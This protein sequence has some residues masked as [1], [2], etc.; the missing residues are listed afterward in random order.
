MQKQSNLIFKKQLLNSIYEHL[1]SSAGDFPALWARRFGLNFVQRK[2]LSCSCDA[3][4][5]SPSLGVSSL[6][7]GRRMA[8]LFLPAT[9]AA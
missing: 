7:L 9:P 1:K 3:L 2:L 5:R 4:H 8:A 6:D